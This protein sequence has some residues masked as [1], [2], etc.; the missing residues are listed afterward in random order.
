MKRLFLLLTASMLAILLLSLASALWDD[1]PRGEEDCAYPGSCGSYIDTNKD[2]LCDHGQEQPVQ[3]EIE[4][5]KTS[6]I[7]QAKTGANYYFLQIAVPLIILYLISYFLSKKGKIKIITHRKIWNIV[8]LVSFLAVAILGIILT[9]NIQYGLQI[10]D[11]AFELK[12]HVE[13]GIVLV[14]VSVFHI[15]WHIPYYKNILKYSNK[16]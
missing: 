3:A 2:G 16:K 4:P 8:L 10:F 13:A 5:S 15:L 9:I 12:W 14:I 7:S 6:V 11:R 1:C